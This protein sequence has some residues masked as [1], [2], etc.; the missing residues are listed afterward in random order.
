MGVFNK[1]KLNAWLAQASYLGLEEVLNGSSVLL[2]E[3]RLD[4][5]NTA[6]RL[7]FEQSATVANASYG[8]KLVHQHAND[9]VG[10]SAS[11]FKSTV[12]GSC[13]LAVRGTDELTRDILIADVL[14]VALSGAARDQ[15]I[16]AY[17]YYKQLTT[18]PGQAV[19]Y[20]ANELLML[21]G[22]YISSYMPLSVS[23]SYPVIAALVA[24]ELAE[25][26]AVVVGERDNDGVD[27]LV[28]DDVTQRVYGE[29]AFS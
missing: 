28:L 4:T 19:L 15:T 12:D 10:F 6:N 22:I 7:A 27:L 1:L 9:N 29:Q 2:D 8:F 16:A 24:N 25:Q 20:T 21:A 3:L 18:A 13:T 14:G 5:F 23:T 26:A 11:V 17:R